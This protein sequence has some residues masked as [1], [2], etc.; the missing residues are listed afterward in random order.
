MEEAFV[1]LDDE[2]IDVGGVQSVG[3][4]FGLLAV[5]LSSVMFTRIQPLVSSNNR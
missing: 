1:A 3:A 4:A 2:P 5:L